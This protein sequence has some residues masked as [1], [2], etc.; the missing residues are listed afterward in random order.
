MLELQPQQGESDFRRRMREGIERAQR[1]E[2]PPP[3]YG[4]YTPPL[5]E[6]PVKDKTM[7]VILDEWRKLADLN[8]W[9]EAMA[10]AKLRVTIAANYGREASEG[11]MNETQAKLFLKR[12]RKAI[13]RK[14]AEMIDRGGRECDL[15]HEIFTNPQDVSR[16]E[17]TGYCTE[18]D[19]A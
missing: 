4:I 13:E 10:A 7:Q 3:G 12:V 11:R 18:C 16:I 17:A 6:N 9:D 5:P 14:R 2:A 8:F 15:C 1:G 19:K